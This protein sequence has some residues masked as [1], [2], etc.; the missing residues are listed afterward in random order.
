MPARRSPGSG[1]CRWQS[2]ADTFRHIASFAGR[3]ESA[4]HI[5]PLHWY[6]ACRLV[7]EGGFPPDEVMPRPPFRIESRGNLPALVHY[8]EAVATGGEQVV[9]GGLKT[10][11]VDVVVTKP[12]LGPVLAIS[13][14]GM[15]GAFR[16]LT[17]RLEE[18]VGECTN[19]HITYPALTLGY[20]LVLNGNRRPVAGLRSALRELQANDLAFDAQG[21]PVSSIVRIH[22]ALTQLHGRRSIRE[23]GSRYEAASLALIETSGPNMGA[24]I[25]TYPS[26]DSP[27]RFENFFSTLYS[28][29]D[30]R[31]VYGAPLLVTRRVTP[32]RLWSPA[33]P[34][35]ASE[36][37]ASYPTLDFVPRMA[38]DATQPA[39]D[40]TV[41]DTTV[42]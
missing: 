40:D 14:K 8:D 25:G 15:Q 20:L 26:A 29:Y 31:F 39:I 3:T 37:A 24:L 33:S 27:L 17:N 22:Y 18:M 16:N 7:L 32:R 12:G 13:L 38:A 19:L 4:E 41:D 6:V 21:K 35:F 2:L 36:T 28:Q 42:C 9:Y 5:K 1:V 23:D 10:K 30:E 11:N 34:V